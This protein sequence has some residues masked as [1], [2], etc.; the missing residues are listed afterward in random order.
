MRKSPQQRFK[1]CRHLIKVWQNLRSHAIQMDEAMKVLENSEPNHDGSMSRTTWFE[2]KQCAEERFDTYMDMMYLK[3][4]YDPDK[5]SESQHTI[6][7]P[8][9]KVA[10]VDLNGNIHTFD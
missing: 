4:C 9:I 1:E 7:K 5:Q 6:G 8:S 3:H 10:Y 2:W